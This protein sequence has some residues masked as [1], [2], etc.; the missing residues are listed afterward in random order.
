MVR[1]DSSHAFM[2]CAVVATLCLTVRTGGATEL[3]DGHDHDHTVDALEPGEHDVEL[4]GVRIHYTVH[5]SGPVMIAH[6][7][8]PGVDARTWGDY[9]GLGHDLTIVTLH[10]RGSG[11]SG[12]APEGEYLLEHYVADLEELRKHLGVERPI[13]IGWSHGGMV[14]Q[15]YAAEHPEALSKLILLSTGACLKDFLGDIEAAA[16]AYR[17]EPWFDDA[18]AALQD[19]WEGN[20]ETDE[21]L[22][23]L[24]LREIKFYF[25]DYGE[26]AAQYVRG[27]EQLVPIRVAPL[28]VFNEQEAPVMDLRELLEKI[29]VPTLVIAGRKDF[30]TTVEMAEDIAAHIKGAQLEVFEASGHFSMVEER[31]AFRETVRAFALGE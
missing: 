18:Y 14:A 7:G 17:D 2:I 6:S 28:Q 12:P 31:E 21:E 3:Y 11:L 9:A 19:E 20:Y 29:T 8:G 13:L 23:A 27:M 10:P 5:G 22:N 24:F 4:N 16:Q 25:A 26:R 15:A 30:I 1:R